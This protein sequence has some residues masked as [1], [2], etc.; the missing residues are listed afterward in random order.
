MQLVTAVAAAP[1]AHCTSRIGNARREYPNKESRSSQDGQRIARLRCRNFLGDGAGTLRICARRPALQERKRCA[2]TENVLG[3]SRK[4]HMRRLAH[5]AI[6]CICLT[7]VAERLA[8]AAVPLDVYGSLPSLEDMALSPDGSRMAFVRTTQDTRMVVVA[9]VADRKAFVAFK[10]GDQKLRYLLWVDNSHLL[11]ETSTTAMPWPFIEKSE[12]FVAQ[13]YD[14]EQR[15]GIPIP[16]GAQLLDSTDY[17]NVVAGHVMVRHVDGHTLLFVPAINISGRVLALVR[18][19]LATARESVVKMGSPETGGW[20]VDAAG[21]VVA[22]EDYDE[23]KEHWTLKVRRDGRL[24]EAASGH[25]AINV[26]SILGFG[27]NGDTL[28]VEVVENENFVWKQLSLQD[29]SMSGPMAEG[30]KLTLPIE[31]H[32]TYRMIG[33]VLADDAR[34]MF[35]DP[36]MQ[37]RWDGVRRAFEGERVNLV[38]WSDDFKKM[39]VLVDGDRDGYIYELVDLNSHTAGPIGDVYEGVAASFEVQR[40]SYAAADGMSIP[41][42]LTLPRRRAPKNLP[43]IV[44]PHGGPAARDHA[45]F[46]WWAQALASQNYAVL[47]PNYRGSNLNWT[48]LSAGFGQWGRKMQSDLS[49]GVR[50]LVKEGI[51]DPARVCIVGASYGGY[52]AFAGVTLEHGVYRC[53]VAVAGLSDLKLMRDW[54]NNEHSHRNS[55]AQRYWDR[56]LGI[57]GPNDPIL[58]VISPIKHVGSVNVPVLIIH[59]RD[60]TVVP[61]EQSSVMADALR[62]AKKDV[63]FVTLQHE[64]HWLSRSETRLQMLQASVAFLRAHNPPD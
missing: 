39:I 51:V 35:F 63:E 6:A 9:T 28:L 7:I 42:Y 11:I 40:I 34:L 25:E 44:L 26:P 16:D 32:R 3:E 2:K 23:Q 46:D 31:D 64:D 21:E 45:H 49:D 54:I 43:L 8:G 56:F 36:T 48:F 53:A 10:V 47:Q 20:L 4:I 59:G 22:E 41:A 57:S 61:F 50:Y 55:L 37:Q 19:D 30:K 33:G 60:D 1:A 58:D 52:A 12:W 38:S 29:G 14:V 13:I 27:P 5:Y 62:H 15:K 17:M 24:K 18:V